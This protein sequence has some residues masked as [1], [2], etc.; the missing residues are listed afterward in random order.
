MK[1]IRRSQNQSNP[2]PEKTKSC[3][4]DPDQRK[5]EDVDLLKC[6]VDFLKDRIAKMSSNLDQ[7]TA[8][9]NEITISDDSKASAGSK[10]KLVKVEDV[11]S[12]SGY[13][14]DDLS[15][16]A[17]MLVATDD[18]MDEIGLVPGEIFPS[19]SS[20]LNHPSVHAIG[21]NPLS[22]QTSL[23]SDDIFVDELFASFNDESMEIEPVLS[24]NT[25]MH[26]QSEV[27][28]SKMMEDKCLS[29]TPEHPNSPD[30]VLITRL[31]EALTV[32][33]RDVQ[34]LLV[35]RL[36][37]TITGSDSVMNHLDAAYKNASESCKNQERM[38]KPCVSFPMIPIHA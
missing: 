25:P 17:P 36:I 35:N 5:T 34:E 29:P 15:V 31:S 33:P 4:A 18:E 6:E 28:E 19:F 26:P 23:S 3:D 7:L 27:F 1:N 11:C 32:L 9:V 30:P 24:M 22:R 21:C 2:V 10:R 38:S 16:H 8:L 12:M 14:S 20:S 13:K 37:A